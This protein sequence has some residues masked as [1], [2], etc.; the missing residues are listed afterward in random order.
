MTKLAKNGSTLTLQ[1]KIWL[2]RGNSHVTDAFCLVQQF[3]ASNATELFTGT[4]ARASIFCP[5]MRLRQCS[6]A[7]FVETNR[8]MMS[9]KMMQIKVSTISDSMSLMPLEKLL[10]KSTCLS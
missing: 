10:T 2:K 6:C 7:C 5:P 9:S 1:L 8:T 4:T 3:N